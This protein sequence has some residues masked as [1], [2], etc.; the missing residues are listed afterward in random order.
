MQYSYR[1]CNPCGRKIRILGK[2]CHFIKTANTST[3][4]IP[5]LRTANILLPR[6]TKP[7]QHEENQNSSLSIR[8]QQSHSRSVVPRRLLKANQESLSPSLC[9]RKLKN[10]KALFSLIL[11]TKLTSWAQGDTTSAKKSHS[12]TRRKS[13]SFSDPETL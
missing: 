4:S 13:L 12:R 1:V 8:G 6:R 11:Q 7:A 5:R 2:F 3:A 9:W 10:L